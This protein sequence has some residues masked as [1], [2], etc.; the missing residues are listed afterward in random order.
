MYGLPHN[1]DREDKGLKM[2]QIAIYGFNFTKKITF[3]GGVLTPIFSSFHDIKEGGWA[4]D[5]YLLTGFFEPKTANYVNQQQLIFDLEAVL[6]FI[7]QKNVIIS[8]ELENDETPFNFKPSLHKILNKKRD[9]GPGAIIIEDS[10]SPK[11]REH[12]ISLAMKK[13]NDDPTQKQDTFRTSFFKS[14]LGFREAL[15]YIDVRYYLLFSALEALC[16]FIKNDY[17]PAKSPQIITDILK[18]Y[19]FNVEKTGHHP[20]QRNIMH[21]CKLRHSLFHNGKYVAYLDE[22]NLAGEIEIKNYSSNLNLLVPLVLMKY[23]G[24]DDEYVNWDSWID[25]HPFISKKK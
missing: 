12:F 10:Y 22:K 5:K 14:M 24:F 1:A 8:G 19:G 16:R 25:R 9:K 20:E 2:T 3:D 18:E 23:I 11:S 17:H 6:S 4:N 15:N 7:E 13:L 21:Y